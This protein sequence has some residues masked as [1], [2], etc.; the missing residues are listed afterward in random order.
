MYR[1]LILYTIVQL[2][3]EN[4]TLNIIECSNMHL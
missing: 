1:V 4:Y 3:I 2:H